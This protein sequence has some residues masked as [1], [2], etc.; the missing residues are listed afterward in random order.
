MGSAWTC[1][2]GRFNVESNLFHDVPLVL[3]LQLALIP[4]HHRTLVS[5]VTCNNLGV[6]YAKVQ[7][8]IEER[9]AERVHP[10]EPMAGRVIA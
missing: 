5:R 7:C 10:H 4:S 6:S 8:T 3:Q 1:G 2:R 9:R